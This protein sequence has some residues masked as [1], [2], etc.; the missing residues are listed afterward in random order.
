MSPEP[1]RPATQPSPEDLR[2]RR[3]SAGLAR[4]DHACLDEFYREW[5]D[6]GLALL[7]AATRR[8]E[9]F[10]LD[11]LHD[12]MLRI[13]RSARPV[14]SDAALAAWTA[15]VI[16]SA[17]LDRLRADRRRADRERRRRPPAATISPPATADDRDIAELRANLARLD[18]QDH[19]LLLARV[20]RGLTLAQAGRAAGVS[21]GAA[22]GRVR[23]ALARL[24]GG[25]ERT[26]DR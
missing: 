8:D 13:V 14:E 17:A 2:A 22:H 5:Y 6:R 9:A 15:R 7:A 24:R 20:V 16:Y 21:Q 10:R 11:A 25:R 18:T 12:A 19:A 23:R 26:D 1:T 4:G 3:L